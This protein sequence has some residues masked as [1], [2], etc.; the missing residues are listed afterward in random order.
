MRWRDPT[1]RQGLN[2]AADT[3]V[4]TF[5][6]SEKDVPRKPVKLDGVPLSR[7]CFAGYD[8]DVTRVFI[9]RK[10]ELMTPITRSANI[11]VC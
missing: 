9:A 1:G 3:L 10:R 11:G 6:G 4:H 2:V 8:V 5:G 7:R